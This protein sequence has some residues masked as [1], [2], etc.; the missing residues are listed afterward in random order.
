MAKLG[1]LRSKKLL[2]LKLPSESI[3]KRRMTP[4]LLFRNADTSLVK[5]AMAN[6]PTGGLAQEG[7]AASLRQ[8]CVGIVGLTP[9]A[10][11]M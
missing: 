2:T 3:R 1:A 4:V 11:Y 10:V 5:R 9:S 7:L 8:Y 6:K